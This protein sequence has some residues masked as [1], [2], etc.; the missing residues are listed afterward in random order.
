M[1]MPILSGLVVS[2]DAF[3]IGLSLGMQKKCRFVHLAII[4]GFLLFLCFVGFFVAEQIYET[5]PFDP[6]LVVGI[7]F[8]ALG[9][10]TILHHFIFR[11][12]Q[13]GKA[14]V[15]I[16]LVMSAEA[17]LIT[18]GITLV[19]LPHSTIA[20]P[21]T[22]SLAHFAYS[23][24]SFRL[25]QSRRVRKISPATAHTVSGIALIIYGLMAIFIEISI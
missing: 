18:M 20:I 3:F 13:K 23:A 9:L 19:F 16:G 15:L 2:V 22:V 7:S 21:I 14:T 4:N 8:I 12:S 25:A 1:F 11:D 17:M 24:L 10:W 5:I 6:D